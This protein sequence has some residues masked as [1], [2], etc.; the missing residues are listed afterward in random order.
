MIGVSF[1]ICCLIFLIILLIFYL[2]KPRLKTINNKLFKYLLIINIIGVFIDVGGFYSFKYLGIGS[3]IN[4]V[5]SKVYLIYYLTYIFCFML[6]IYNVST[7]KIKKNLTKFL[8]IFSLSVLLVVF[9]PIELHFENDIGYSYGLSVNLAY[10][11]AGIMMAL[12]VYYLFKYIKKNG[13][14]EYIPLIAFVV[15]TVITV[16]VQKIK[17]E[18]TM[19]LLSNTIVTYLMYFTIE[20][21]D[22]QMMEE[23]YKNKKLIEKSSE[24]TSNFLFRMTEDIKKPINDIIDIS[25]DMMKISDVSDLKDGSKIVNN[26]AKELEYLVNDALDVS[27]MS[28]KNLKIF[29]NRY[30]P[31]TLFDE[32]KALIETEISREVRFEYHISSTIPSY[33]YGD[34]IKLKQAVYSVLENSVQNTKEGY[35]S[36]SIDSIVKYDVCRLLIS[37]SD[38][39]SGMNIEEVNNILS[40]NI[41]DLS[42]IDL[43]SEKKIYNLKEIKKMTMIMGGNLI[44][45]SEE[46]KGTSVSITIDQKIVESKN[47]DLSKKLDLYEQ[48]LHKNKRI[49]VVDDDA[50]ELATI[51]KILEKNDMSVNSSLFGRDLLE[52][53]SRGQNFDLIILD[54]ETSTI[55]GYEM[56]KE[57][58]KNEK[59]KTPV[60]IMIDDSKEFIKLHFLKDGFA[61]VIMKSKLKS[62]IERVLK[63]F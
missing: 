25:S 44:V 17:P 39:G 33:L 55:S 63:R 32:L 13:Y 16:T 20:N 45:K 15:L 38:S 26:K 48:S 42:Q 9:L 58:K 22:I 6:Y 2:S 4:I 60:I 43:K 28:T 10:S 19:L 35:I 34:S 27:L 56:L 52:K 18:V 46:D 23:L 40:L 36:L 54:D 30:N 41:D 61:D 1:S 53:I 31:N 24:D 8:T 62:E 59:F 57:L 7:G 14:K 51:V 49:M 3:Y 21:P 5:I 50:G 12:M 11:I 37:I 47:L 29:N